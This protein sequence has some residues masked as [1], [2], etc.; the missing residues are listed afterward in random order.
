MGGLG[1]ARSRVGEGE[2]PG[3]ERLGGLG[4]ALPTTDL[5]QSGGLAAGASM[6]SPL[7]PRMRLASSLKISSFSRSLSM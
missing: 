1:V 7:A 2:R 3:E 4:T 5:R 6:T